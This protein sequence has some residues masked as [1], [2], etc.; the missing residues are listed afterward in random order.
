MFFSPRNHPPPP[1]TGR[2]PFK[3]CLIEYA[4]PFHHRRQLFLAVSC[5]ESLEHHWTSALLF[6]RPAATFLPFCCPGRGRYGSEEQRLIYGRENFIQSNDFSRTIKIGLAPCQVYTLSQCAPSPPGRPR[7]SRGKETH[8]GPIAKGWRS[9][10]ADSQRSL[11]QPDRAVN[12][13]L[14]MALGCVDWRGNSACCLK[15]VWCLAIMHASSIN[16]HNEW[17]SRVQRNGSCSSS[18][19]IDEVAHA[20]SS[21]WR[22]IIKTTPIQW[23]RADQGFCDFVCIQMMMSTNQQHGTRFAA[24][25]VEEG[26]EYVKDDEWR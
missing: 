3:S 9:I 25:G 13:G 4:S 5:P 26:V 11:G 21:T 1:T 24:E 14:V 12:Q 8:N 7:P 10:C 15:P 18:R 22:R 19:R 17:S 16:K 23:S 20:P 6:V 2:S